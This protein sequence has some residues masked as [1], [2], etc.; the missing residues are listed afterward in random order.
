MYCCCLCLFRKGIN[1]IMNATHKR[2]CSGTCRLEIYLLIV[3]LA[4]IGDIAVT[5]LSAWAIKTDFGVYPEPALPAMGPR[6]SKVVD[7][8]FGTTILRVTDSSDATTRAGTQYASLQAFNKDNTYI[9]GYKR[10]MIT[11]GVIFPFDATNFTAG[12]GFTLNS[13]PALDDYWLVWSGI[14][15][16][17][18][19][20]TALNSFW[21]INV[22]TRQATLIKDLS[23]QGFRGGR[24][25]QMSASLNDDVFAASILDSEGA[26]AG[27][28]VYQRSTDRVLLRILSNSVNEVNEVKLDK[29]GRYLIVINTDRT[30]VIYDLSPTT[31]ML[32][33]GRAIEVYANGI[34]HHDSGHGTLF[35]DYQTANSLAF[36]QLATPNIFQKL[37]PGYWSYATQDDHFSMQADD[38]L[39]ALSSRY[40]KNAG[41]VSKPF[42]NEIVQIATDDSNRVRRLAHH[43]SKVVNDNYNAQVKA[44]ISRDGRFVAFT[45][46]WGNANGRT[47]I[48]IVQ[49]LLPNGD[50]T[51]PAPPAGVSVRP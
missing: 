7:P 39:W 4:M 13:P 35:N 45:S 28:L 26:T 31:P 15:P 47:D 25:T 44:T 48:Y 46:N 14:S 51:P 33:A 9:A 38:E 17:I 18:T 50:T 27:Y 40:H 6:G 3:V 23:N 42:D 30:R 1:T 20:G 12:A 24:I 10:S 16:N 5:E 2:L 34:S 32:V 43:R 11:R 22:A 8:T 29:S 19:F 21:Q 36:R 49:I 37:I 41:P